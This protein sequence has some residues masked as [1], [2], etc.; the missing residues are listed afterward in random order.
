MDNHRRKYDNLMRQLQSLNPSLR[1]RE[2][3]IEQRFC[4]LTHTPDHPPYASMI[5]KAISE[6]NE[7]G[8]SSEE[9]IIKFIEAEYDDL[10]IAHASYVNH[11]LQKLITKG[12]IVCNSANCYIL[13]FENSD[14]VHK[15]KKGQ[16]Q[17]RRFKQGRRK[18][19]QRNVKEGVQSQQRQSIE[20]SQEHN[21][22]CGKISEGAQ[23][24]KQAEECQIGL[25]GEKK[26]Q[27]NAILIEEL[28]E[29]NQQ[30][31]ELNVQESQV[32]CQ[33]IEGNVEEQNQEEEGHQARENDEVTETK[34]QEVQE[35]IVTEEPHHREQKS[36][37]PEESNLIQDQETEAREEQNKLTDIQIETMVEQINPQAQFQVLGQRVEGTAEEHNQEEESHQARKNDEVTET[38]LQEDVVTEEPHH[39][40]QKSEKPKESNQIQD[41]ETEAR[42]EQIQLTDTQ[43]E[44]MAEQINPQGQCQVLWQTVEGTA[45]EHNQEEES[46]QARKHDEVTETELQEDVTEELHHIEQ[47]SET[48]EES[49]QTLDQES[50]AREEQVQLADIQFETMVEQINPLGQCFELSYEE[51]KLQEQQ[52]EV[53]CQ[54]MDLSNML[55]HF[56]KE[57]EDEATVSTQNGTANQKDLFGSSHLTKEEF[58][59]L[60]KKTNKIEGKLIDIICSLNTDGLECNNSKSI[61]E[62]QQKKLLGNPLQQKKKLC[63]KGSES[64]LVRDCQP[65]QQEICGQL[66][67]TESQPKTILASDHVPTGL[68]EFEQNCQIELPIHK[69]PPEVEIIIL[70]QLNR[71]QNK[72]VK[73]CD[74]KEAVKSQSKSM[75]VSLDASSNSL[76]DKNENSQ[77]VVE[78][79]EMVQE[80]NGGSPTTDPTINFIEEADISRP[81]TEISFGDVQFMGSEIHQNSKH[82]GPEKLPESQLVTSSLNVAMELQTVDL[83][84]QVEL[85][86]TKTFPAAIKLS[87][88]DKAIA[89]CSQIPTNLMQQP[90]LPVPEISAEQE[91]SEANVN[92]NLEHTV[93]EQQDLT[94]SDA[95]RNL[96]LQFPVPNRPPELTLQVDQL[97]TD[98]QQQTTFRNVVKRPKYKL[99]QEQQRENLFEE[100]P[101]EHELTA[102][103]HSFQTQQQMQGQKLQEQ[104]PPL[105]QIQSKP[106]LITATFVAKKHGRTKKIPDQQQLRK[107]RPRGPRPSKSEPVLTTVEADDDLTL[108]LLKAELKQN[109]EASIHRRSREQGSKTEV[110]ISQSTE[111]EPLI[112]IWQQKDRHKAVV[113]ISQPTEQQVNHHGQRKR[114][115]SQPT[116]ITTVDS[117]VTSQQQ[118]QEQLQQRKVQ[119]QGQ[120][121]SQSE[122]VVGKSTDE[123]LPLQSQQ[124][125]QMKPRRRGRPPK[126]KPDVGTFMR[127]LSVLDHQHH[128]QQQSLCQTQGRQFKKKINA[129]ATMKGLLLSDHENHEEQHQKQAQGKPAKMKTIADASMKGSVFSD[130][131]SHG[132][133][134]QNRA[135]GRPPKNKPNAD[136]SMKGISVL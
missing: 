33:T 21:Q 70:E 15:L 8:G 55:V 45:E 22:V 73:L 54:I 50:T 1:F 134:Q 125:E 68:M 124:S 11:H 61:M 30:Q 25:I 18:G 34:G 109:S 32:L 69:R 40:K 12:E 10:P 78:R 88:T 2:K 90:C 132:E 105:S 46:H 16:K 67:V 103:A 52:M 60:L 36:E 121:P 86:K 23:E 77:V 129:D 87:I 117:A 83:E 131:H 126:L 133:Q 28:N 130:H 104:L 136:A 123:S 44:T 65:Q 115:K 17:L 81:E 62:M 97:S 41:Q 75:V 31:M 20:K 93:R 72:Q 94:T 76:H 56:V 116:T 95:S 135:Q 79:I 7:Q 35:N 74:Q 101:T 108:A 5:Q 19:R 39:K 6:L 3:E 111:Q 84:K 27:G 118:T 14:S 113:K 122:S 57:K 106:Q 89:A 80:E 100:R 9:A 4:K 92:I 59:E 64:L 98:N 66:E 47:K 29:Q 13:S 58:L 114:L 49:N 71:E 85:Q 102:V 91:A 43:I 107:L 48:R 112:R 53:C 127:E 63:L 42:E 99:G 82:C 120:A 128:V 96:D 119:P 110:E 38:E 26:E 24:Q 51:K 37:K